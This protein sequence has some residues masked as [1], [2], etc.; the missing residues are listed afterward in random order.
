VRLG[1]RKAK[2]RAAGFLAA[3]LV[4][5]AMLLGSAESGQSAASPSMTLR[6]MSF[7]IFYGGDEL[8]LQ[9]RQFC[10]DPAGCPETLDQV[11]NAIRASG[12]DVV[13]LE[14]ATMN[15]CPL[16][17]KLGWHCSARTQIISRY[18]I[19][20]PPGANGLYVFIEPLPGRVVAVSDVHLPAD[21]YG[22][23][24][25][26]DGATLDQVLQLE[27]DLRVPA[28]QQEVRELPKLAARGIP[29]F[30]T[31]DFNTPSHLDWTQAVADVRADVP[32]PVQWPVSKALNNAGFK[33]SFRV[34]HPDPVAKPGFTWTPGSPE[35]ERVEVHDR[36][37]WVLSTGP[38][39]ATASSVVGEGGNPNT[40]IAV[41][42]WPSDH[43]GIVS[44][45]DVTPA[46]MPL[47]VAVE[48]RSLEQGDTLNVRFHGTGRTG[49]RVAIV[50]AGAA[51][52]TA[53]ASK[54]TAGVTDGTLGFATSTLAPAAYEAVL[55]NPS[56]QLVARSPFWLY[57]RGAVTTVSTSKLVYKVGETITVS[58]TKAPGMKFDWLGV[59]TAGDSADN[60]NNSTC[61]AGYCGNGH[62]LLYEYTH[63]TIEGTT[64]FGPASQ[65]GY[66]TWP[67]GTGNYEIRLLLDDGYR[68]AASSP[69]FKIVQP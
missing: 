10:R 38:A 9:T 48:S 35:G 20:D 31:G 14:E 17:Q 30:L 7:N 29:V 61:S 44:T 57:A 22:P 51:P 54:S 58:W 5:A 32:F 68:S 28:I 24:Q 69:Q 2:V 53:L 33:D 3:A 56:G 4:A 13:G 12:A 46:A 64:T 65:I 43:R 49:E 40:D 62:Y 26:R 23:Y 50:R 39:H 19:V 1:T 36:I 18:P 37:D 25:I 67:L 16:A 34:V 21:P 15:T 41:D 47:L 59:Y 6:V 42:P 60:P 8:N 52:S 11:A 55:I 45:F 63:N 27:N 66:K